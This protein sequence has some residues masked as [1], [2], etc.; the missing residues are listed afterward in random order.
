MLLK[1]FF[2]QGCLADIFWGYQLLLKAALPFKESGRQGMVV[3]VGLK[4]YPAFNKGFKWLV[5]LASNPPLLPPY[6]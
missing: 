1:H 4:I 6:F 3:C 5:F 2:Y